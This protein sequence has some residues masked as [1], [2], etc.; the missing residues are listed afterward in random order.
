VDRIG[1][2]DSLGGVGTVCDV[3]LDAHGFEH[4]R[5]AVYPGIWLPTGAGEEE[6]QSSSWDSFGGA[7]NGREI[8]MYAIAHH[9]GGMYGKGRAELWALGG[10]NLREFPR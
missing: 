7:L 9:S 2:D 5:E 1:V 10:L 3:G 4:P 8:R 6:M